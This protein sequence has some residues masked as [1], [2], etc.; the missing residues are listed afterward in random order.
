[1]T[2]MAKRTG[3][4][5]MRMKTRKVHT[6]ISIIDS[7]SGIA[8]VLVLVISVIALAIM[9]A[10][11]YMLTSGTQISGMQKRYRTAQEAGLGGADITYLML[12]SRGNPNIPL[13]GFTMTPYVLGLATLTTIN[14]L[15]IPHGA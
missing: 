4:K 9:S 7:E 14:G 6:G 2:E 8:L 15:Y 10:L 5:I 13:P 11:I 1:M 3:N 12:A